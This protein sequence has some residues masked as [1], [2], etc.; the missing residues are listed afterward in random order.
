MDAQTEL[1]LNY[2]AYGG[3]TGTIVATPCT[4]AA[5]QTECVAQ[6]SWATSN[7]TNVALFVNGLQA[8][9]QPNIATTL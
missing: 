8:S 5:G 3:S 1:R 2:G 9:N 6:A 4:L 7:A